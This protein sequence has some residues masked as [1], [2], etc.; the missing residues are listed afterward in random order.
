MRLM[1]IK[2]ETPLGSISGIDHIYDMEEYEFL[3]A[4]IQKPTLF[5]E[6]DDQGSEMYLCTEIKNQSIITIKV[7][8]T[9]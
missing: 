2:A 9:K 5:I 3:K 1:K 7:W 4:D 6:Y 8:E